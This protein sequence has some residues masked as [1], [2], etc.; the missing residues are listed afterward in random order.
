MAL[1]GLKVIDCSQ[2]A[3]VP[4]AARHLADF[5]AD[6]IHVENTETG[7]YWRVFQEAQM[8]SQQCAPSEFNYNWENFNRNKRSMT[9]NLKTENGRAIMHKMVAESDVFLSNL[10]THELKNFQVDYET[11]NKINPRLIWGNINGYGKSGPDKDLPAYDTTAY[12]TRAAI[13]YMLSTAGVPCLGYRPAMGDTVA[14]LG[15]A[16]G[17]MQALYVR[18]KTGEGQAVDLSLFHTGLYQMS[19]DISGA[20]I[21]GLD[22]ADWRQS[23]PPEIQQK[24]LMSIME[25]MSSM[26]MVNMSPLTG[27]YTT[28]D[29]QSL[30]FVI[31]QPDR[32][33]EKFCKAVDR[34]DLLQNPKYDTMEGRNE[35]LLILRQAFMEAFMKKNYDEWVPLLEGIPYARRQTV[36]D[37]VNDVQA[38]EAGCIVT[39]EHPEAGLIKQL[40]NPVMMSKTP[41]TV[42]MPAP[43]FGQHTEEI[44]LEYGYT[45]DDIAVFQEDGTIGGF[46]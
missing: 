13:P 33:W 21:T 17:I 40:A 28:K 25:A 27:M 20:L 22:F 34:E 1:D 16:Y 19:F 39:Y 15:L 9:L 23:P 37:A 30:M 7:D 24:V 12:W 42:R 6:V 46:E 2:V 14:G 32:Y 43:E 18:E 38:R 44:L 35:D 10:R 3:A 5:G 4:I 45:W 31:L 11:L 41:A 29:N 8:A 26:T 36:L